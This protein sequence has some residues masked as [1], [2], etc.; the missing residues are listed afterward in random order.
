MVRNKRSLET[1]NSRVSPPNKMPSR[2]SNSNSRSGSDEILSEIK[3]LQER[4]A[5]IEQEVAEITKYVREV[6]TLRAE[7]GELRGVCEGYQRLELENKKRCV[8]LKGLKFQTGSQYET[9]QQT[10]AALAEFF[11][12]LDVT[13]HLVDYQRLG[14]RRENED[15]SKVSVRVQFVDVDQKYALFEK[16]Q[17]MGRELQDVSVLTDYPS[18]QLTQFK[19][20]SSA[21]YK[22][23]QEN[24]GTKTRVVPK[25]L[26]LI[27]QRRPNATGKWTTVSVQATVQASGLP[28]EELQ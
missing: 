4:F 7:V 6:E 24:P 12:R 20:L 9:R 17:S 3:Q 2:R 25:G 19:H 18:F 21:A 28:V 27:L 1:D 13:P 26:G 16:L 8:L 5:K 22:I 14:G 10:R 11:G 15:G 23:R